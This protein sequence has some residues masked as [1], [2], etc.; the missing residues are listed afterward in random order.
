MRPPIH[1]PVII[2]IHAPFVYK[3]PRHTL[4]SPD[5]SFRWLSAREKFGSETL[6]L[7]QFVFLGLTYEWIGTRITNGLRGE[8]LDREQQL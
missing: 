3:F 8:L 1:E 2:D 5:F 6:S 4:V 7:G